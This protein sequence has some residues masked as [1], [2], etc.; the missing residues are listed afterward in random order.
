MKHSLQRAVL[1]G[2]AAF[3]VAPQL[4]AHG[5]IQDPPSRNWFCG[6][7]TKPDE[8][9]NGTA[10]YPECK[11][12]FDTNMTGS[13]NFMSVLTH[14]KGR[15][16]V[17]PLPENV[18]GFNAETFNK[19]ATPWDT[20]MQWPT[21]KVTA[22]RK[23][24]TWNIAWGPHFSDTQEFRYYITKPGFQWSPT[25]ALTW[26]D[27]EDQPFCTLT[28]DDTKPNGNPDVVP[29]KGTVLFHTFCQ[30]PARTGR[31]VVYGEWGRNYFT[32]ERFHSCVDVEYEG[33]S[34]KPPTAVI[35]FKPDV[36]EVTGAT[37]VVLDGSGSKGKGLTYAWSLNPNDLKSAKIVNAD[38]AKA[39]LV[40]TEPQVNE[41][42]Q[43]SLLVKNAA[44]LTDT[45]SRTLLHKP[46]G[47]SKWTDLGPLT[48][49][50]VTLHA[51]DS[52]NVRTVLTTGTDN[53]VPNPALVLT[54][55][56]SSATQWPLA[57]GKAVNATD[58]G[59]QIG[60]VNAKGAIK[61]IADA[62]ANRMYAEKGSKIASAFL[63]VT[64]SNKIVATYTVTSDWGQGY[65]ASIKVSNNDSVPV[66]WK[67]TLKINGTVSNAWNLVWSQAG[68]TMTIEGVAPN[69]ILQ[70][71]ANYTDGGFCA[72]K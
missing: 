21:N 64:I 70:P 5:L 24:F 27:F 20:P 46:T 25:K 37:T 53:Y 51:N 19:G 39:K 38:Q 61:P 41:N 66:Q 49:T 29:D 62:T 12:A 9:A 56:N 52:V 26:A 44:G 36:T 54:E 43:I 6:A 40:L 10:K 34:G 4:M 50:P 63:Q 48:T 7:I 32:Y 72:N 14:T 57:L 23:E 67:A 30:L 17:T 16:E 28:Y 71:G 59:L 47:G 15:A 2:A 31:H 33:S 18:C 45:E 58:S 60:V 13:Y 1:I 11:T 8:I 22:G 68:D 3:V 35:G 65:C 55:A 69:N 42:L